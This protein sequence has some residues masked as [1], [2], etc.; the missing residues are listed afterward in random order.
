MG[1]DVNVRCDDCEVDWDEEQVDLLPM[2]YLFEG[3]RTLAELS[4]RLRD[5]AD[6][7]DRRN[8]EGWSLAGPVDGGY[9]HL[10]R[11]VE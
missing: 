3:C 11:E 7:L 6:E 2:K 5:V 10:V 4:V 9:A 1:D 8:A